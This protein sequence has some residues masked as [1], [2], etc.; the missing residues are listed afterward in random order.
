MAILAVLESQV[1]NTGV[2]QRDGGGQGRLGRPNACDLGE[3]KEGLGGLVE[4]A[5]RQGGAM[6]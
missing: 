4:A 2:P 1:R 5:S 6:G 3:A